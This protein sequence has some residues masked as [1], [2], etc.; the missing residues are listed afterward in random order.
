MKNPELRLLIMSKVVNTYN[1]VTIQNKQLAAKSER[2]L[3]YLTES[4]YLLYV[5]FV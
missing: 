5:L 3:Y 1:T 4:Y 2:I